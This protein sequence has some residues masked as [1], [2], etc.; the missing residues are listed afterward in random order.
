MEKTGSPMVDMTQTEIDEIR[1]SENV[2]RTAIHP[3]TGK[4]IPWPMRLSSFLPINI[5][6]TFGMLIAAPTPFNTIF[7]QWMNQ[8]CNAGLNYGNRNAS[9][10]Y[11]NKDVAVS[12]CMAVLL[13]ASV[14]LSI[15]KYFSRWTKHMT[16]TKLVMMN[17][18]STFVACSSAGYLNAYMMRQTELTKGIDVFEKEHPETPIGKS[19]VAASEAVFQTAVSRFV[20]CIPLLFPGAVFVGLDKLRLMPHKFWPKTLVEMLVFILELYIA[21]PFAIA[22]YPTMATL[23]R[24]KIEK[25]FQDISGAK[26]FLFNKGL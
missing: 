16:G 3:D 5:P 2:V 12:Y 1:I 9:S 22:C 23:K 19:K 20:L 17:S 10:T 11:T 14:S 8:T 26:E 25:E 21:V 4:F 7:W 18:I 24:D 15:R 13:G 6:I